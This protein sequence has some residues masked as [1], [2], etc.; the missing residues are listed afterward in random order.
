M[1]ALVLSLALFAQQA[2]A[3]P[4]P[5]VTGKWNVTLEMQSTTA[6]PTIELTQEGEKLSGV[7]VSGRY[8]KVPLSGTIKGRA[9]AFSFTLSVEGSEM[10]MTYKGEVAA[11]YQSIKGVAALGD[12][13]EA[14]WT[15][16]RA[17]K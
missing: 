1:T 16:K 14:T 7:Y 9:L 6:T 13:G 12:A 2:P 8:G 3:K 10:S 4:A 15:A 5:S 11:D 17:E